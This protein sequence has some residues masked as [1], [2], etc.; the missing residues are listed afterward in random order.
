MLS[1][2]VRLPMATQRI[3]LQAF[4][5]DFLFAHQNMEAVR[6]CWVLGAGASVSSDIS[7]GAVLAQKWFDQVYRAERF[8]GETLEQF[9]QRLPEEARKH[10]INLNGFDFRIPGINYSALYDY[11]F[12]DDAAR[13]FAQLETTMCGKDPGLGYAVLA[14]FLSQTRHR[15]VITV[16]FDNLVADAVGIHTDVFPL[17]CGHESLA[18][19]IKLKQARPLVLKVHRDLLLDPMSRSQDLEKLQREWPPL[20]EKIFTEY[21]PIVIGYDGNDR[22]LM[23][24][25]NSHPSLDGRLFWCHLVGNDPRQEIQ[26]LV[27]RHRGR[28][29]AI[30]GFDELLFRLGAPLEFVDPLTKMRERYEGRA[31]KYTERLSELDRVIKTQ[32]EE[33]SLTPDTQPLR[34][35]V[36]KAVEDAAKEQGWL[37]WALQA[38][39]END[40]AKREAIFRDG[41]SACPESGDLARKFAVFLYYVKKD[42]DAAELTFEKAWEVDPKNVGIA[43]D[44]ANFLARARREHARAEELYRG[45]LE[46]EPDNVANMGA[47]A[48]FLVKAKADVVEAEHWYRRAL[49]LDPA[50]PNRVAN[51]ANFLDFTKH[52][53]GEAEVLYRRAVELAPT[54]LTKR[55]QLSQFLARLERFDEARREV[56]E[57]MRTVG[58]RTMP[59]AYVV[60]IR[61]LVDRLEGAEGTQALGRLKTLL[62]G[63]FPRGSSSLD[64]LVT[65]LVTKLPEAE[66]SFAAKLANAI[67]SDGHLAAL[68]DEELWKVKPIALDAPWSD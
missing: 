36:Q 48:N 16:N 51:L 54:D 47:F 44:Y 18:N 23:E 9:A 22:T 37:R 68:E 61:W 27:A 25:M 63:G 21:T 35:A 20:L 50:N 53:S 42:L 28:L 59:R 14:R 3:N 7:A 57:A 31:K 17:V 4:V 2:L 12:R 6:Y 38:E 29:V 46:I 64:G 32:G 5:D 19:Y 60:F 40:V 39:Q 11:R 65:S 34:E 13:G 24:F 62:L 26:E 52:D 30:E 49:E 56:T 41:L 55:V 8:D 58:G 33:L 10:D 66:R 43:I 45:A 1:R 15:V 67:K